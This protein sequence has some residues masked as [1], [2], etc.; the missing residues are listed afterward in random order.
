MP[1]F[2]PFVG[3][4]PHQNTP[5]VS[6]VSW[7]LERMNEGEF[8]MM[9]EEIR[10]AALR[11]VHVYLGRVDE[12]YKEKKKKK[13]RELERL[14]RS[15]LQKEEKTQRK[16]RQMFVRRNDLVLLDASTPFGTSGDGPH[17]PKFKLWTWRAVLR[18]GALCGVGV[19]SGER[20]LGYDSPDTRLLYVL[21]LGTLEE[22][23]LT[24]TSVRA[25]LVVNHDILEGKKL[26]EG[27]D[28]VTN[29]G[30]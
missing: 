25:H 11:I 22:K 28:E 3:V 27:K 18:V 4:V 5:S 13:K 17:E 21:Q 14:T 1:T 12:I 19:G 8:Y 20:R 7:K 24:S 15:A 29:Q 10:R 30:T 16:T 6:V 23:F 2:H 9:N 26:R